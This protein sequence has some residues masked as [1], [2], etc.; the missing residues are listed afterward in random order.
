M[1]KTL[2]DEIL[3]RLPDGVTAHAILSLQ[4][5]L[6]RHAS[7]LVKAAFSDRRA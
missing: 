2:R 5:G 7:A 6:S 3:E 4:F 1:D